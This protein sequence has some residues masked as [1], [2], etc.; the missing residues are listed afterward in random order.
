MPAKSMYD[1]PCLTG[2]PAFGGLPA[3]RARA[4]TEARHVP[5]NLDASQ[6]DMTESKIGAVRSNIGK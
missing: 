1:D 5:G 6:P 4:L 3:A 2:T